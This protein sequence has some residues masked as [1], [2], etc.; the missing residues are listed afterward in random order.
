MERN[1]K[2]YSSNVC[3]Q[4]PKWQEKSWEIRKLINILQWHKDDPHCHDSTGNEV[5]PQLCQFRKINESLCVASIQQLKIR[6]ISLT[7][8]EYI[9]SKNNLPT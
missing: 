9:M 1:H 4:N 8:Q 2:M 3:I 6:N 7:N 5:L